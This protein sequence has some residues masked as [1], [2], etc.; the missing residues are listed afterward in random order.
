MSSWHAEITLTQIALRRYQS[1]DALAAYEARVP[2]DAVASVDLRHGTAWVERM[3]VA[4][5][6]LTREDRRQIERL[7]RDHGATLLE[8]D[9]HG[10]LVARDK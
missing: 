2:Y 8:A 3:L 4:G 7:L 1:D 6:A 10:H 5:P 9:R